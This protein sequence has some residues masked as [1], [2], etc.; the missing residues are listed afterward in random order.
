ME[1]KQANI[2][3]ENQTPE[4]K[5]ITLSPDEWL[6]QEMGGIQSPAEFESLPGLIFIENKTVDF[7]ISKEDM[8]FKEWK[9][10]VNKVI[11]KIIPVTHNS[12]KKNLWL[13]TKNPLY[14]IILEKLLK[15]ETKFKVLQ[16]GNKG[17]TKYVLVEN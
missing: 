11:K 16:T 15:G 13:N 1:E 17:T 2:P 8:P 4:N 5:E 6:K 9:D 12:E 10:I 7:E 14:K 3:Q